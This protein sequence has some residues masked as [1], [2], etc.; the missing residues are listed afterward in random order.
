M[1]LEEMGPDGEV[2]IFFSF[3]QSFAFLC[4]L[5]QVRIASSHLYSV[6]GGLGVSFSPNGEPSKTNCRQKPEHMMQNGAT[7]TAELMVQWQHELGSLGGS[8]A[9]V[10]AA[11]PSKSYE[12]VGVPSSQSPYLQDF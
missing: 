11:I 1:G 5:E 10:H 6:G 2:I 3:C 9:S 8:S 12:L 4:G 7:D